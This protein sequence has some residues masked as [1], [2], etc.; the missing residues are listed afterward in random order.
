MLLEHP[1]E[2]TMSSLTIST[3][4]RIKEA[5]ERYNIDAD[6]VGHDA[7]FQAIASRLPLLK[8]T[9]SARM[10]LREV[11]RPPYPVARIAGAS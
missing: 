6:A 11:V 8:L 1:G 2:R 5:V 4:D 9:P 7:L 3:S 10:L